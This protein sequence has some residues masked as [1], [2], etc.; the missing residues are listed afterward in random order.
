MKTRIAL[1]SLVLAL[2]TATII[3]PDE[4]AVSRGPEICNLSVTADPRSGDV[5]ISWS[6]G[7]L[8]FSLVR[9]DATCFA[10]A[11]ELRY[12]V[13]GIRVHRYVDVAAVRSGRRYWYQV[14][15]QNS[16]TETYYIGPPDPKSSDPKVIHPDGNGDCGDS[17]TCKGLPRKPCTWQ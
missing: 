17:D 10:K 7:T 6:G 15:D 9:A 8:P 4:I 2:T 11:S 13:E 14:F 12:L 3:Y 1:V 5:I 16:P